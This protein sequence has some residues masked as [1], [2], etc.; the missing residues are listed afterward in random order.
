MQAVIKGRK[1]ALRI[2]RNK[3]E[4]KL[5]SLIEKRKQ[6]ITEAKKDLEEKKYVEAQ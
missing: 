2:R 6:I 5:A 1:M 4:A 3:V